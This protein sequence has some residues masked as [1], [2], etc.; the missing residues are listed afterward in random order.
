MQNI[1]TN[2][3]KHTLNGLSARTTSGGKKGVLLP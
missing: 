2:D 1:L 3:I